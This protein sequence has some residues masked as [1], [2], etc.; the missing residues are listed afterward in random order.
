MRDKSEHIAVLDGVRAYAIL[1]VMGFH[2]WQQS[3]LQNLI[4]HDLLQPFGVR[5]FSLTWVPRTGYMF[6]D[7]LLL[8]SGFCLFLP[9]A[10]QMADPLAREPDAPGL[11]FRKRAAR[12]LPSYYF[13]LLVSLLFL[14]R[15]AQYARFGD[16]LLDLFAHLTC[17]HTLWPQSYIGTKFPACSGTL[18]VEVQFYLIFPLL[19]RL[20]RRFPLQCWAVLSA[21]AQLY[22]AL[23]ARTAGGGADPLHINQLP[24]ML[25]VYANGMLAAIVWC[26]LHSA[27]R[28]LPARTPLAA[29]LLCAVSFAA[30]VCMLHDGLDRAAAIQRWQVDY[31]FPVFGVRQRVHPVARPLLP[32]GAMALCKPRRRLHR[33]DLVQPVHLAHDDPA[34][35]QGLASAALPRRA[36]DAYAWPQSANGAPWHFAWQVQYTVLFWVASLVVAA[37]ATYLIEKPAA[38]WLLRR[39]R[40]REDAKAVR[41]A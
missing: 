39:R 20:F 19:A 4:P 30:I 34:A 26:R 16:Y 36:A 29:T 5:D 17:T 21:L 14:V 37:L 27:R 11:F 12:I 7:V 32:R 31:R 41:P 3:W 13:C 40:K 38:K 6:V 28:R 9:Y 1:I 22:I 25:G 18:S 8:L 10:R 2:L 24:A 15:P 35:V 33:A 23:F